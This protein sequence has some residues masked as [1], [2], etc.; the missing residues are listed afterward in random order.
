MQLSALMDPFDSQLIDSQTS[1][2]FLDDS[3]HLFQAGDAHGAMRSLCDG[4]AAQ[5]MML[6]AAAWRQFVEDARQHPAMRTAYRCPFTR[7]AATRPAGYPGDASLIDH[8]YGYQQPAMAAL[9]AAIYAFTT[10]APATRAVRYR[11]HVLA[12]AIDRCLHERAAA[13]RILAIACGHLRELDASRAISQ[14]TPQ[15]FIALDQDANSLA[16]VERCFGRYGVTPVEATIKDLIAG[17]RSFD[18]LD[19]VYAAGLYDYLN[20]DLAQRLTARLFDMLAPGGS[21]LLANFVPDVPDVGFMEAAMDW[22]LIYRDEAAMRCTLGLV[23]EAA[24]A[25][26]T[27][28]RDP[29]DNVTFMIVKKST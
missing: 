27:Q 21:L 18:T 7:H 11:R 4:L 22:W 20:D 26:V 2:A 3:E 19:L 25:E 14:I 8:I 9:E 5:R 13:S 28:F 24:I 10:S 12:L 1:N 15:R 29:D 6:E 23:S 17:R 16:E